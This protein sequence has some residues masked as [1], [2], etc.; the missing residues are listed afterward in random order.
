[1]PAVA[2]PVVVGSVVGVPE[3]GTVLVVSQLVA[4][5]LVLPYVTTSRLVRGP[6]L[7]DVVDPTPLVIGITDPA[8]LVI[9]THVRVL[10]VGLP[11]L[12]LVGALVVGSN[13]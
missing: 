13:L 1:M 7:V 8:T 11:E 5:H 2:S 9:G 10:G 4:A 3:S 6:P 12:L